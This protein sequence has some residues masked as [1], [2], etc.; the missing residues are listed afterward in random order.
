[1]KFETHGGAAFEIQDDWWACADMEEFGR[2]EGTHYP[3]SARGDLAVE[4]V[5]IADITHQQPEIWN[6]SPHSMGVLAIW[7]SSKTAFCDFG[8]GAHADLR[9]GR[10]QRCV[11]VIPKQN[12]P[13][14]EQLGL[15]PEL[16]SL[17]ESRRS[18]P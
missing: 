4:I 8:V 7:E 10:E 18:E 3:C 1:V 9:T 11:D 17:R 6:P 16:A 13:S 15:I 14:L 5:P 12:C 2:G